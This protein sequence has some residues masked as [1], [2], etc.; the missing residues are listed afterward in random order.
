M[1]LRLCFKIKNQFYPRNLPQQCI[2]DDYD[3]FRG[4][5]IET[6]ANPIKQLQSGV[7]LAATQEASLPAM[8]SKL[9]QKS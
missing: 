8:R 9:G 1:V 6:A 5:E 3:N 4:T 7:K 2:G